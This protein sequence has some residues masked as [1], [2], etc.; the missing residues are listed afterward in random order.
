MY[1]LQA[2]QSTYELVEGPPWGDGSQRQSRV[3]FIGR[4][5]PSEEALRTALL[6]CRAAPADEGHDKARLASSQLR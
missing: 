4:D 2:V 5:L 1:A 3:T 6:T